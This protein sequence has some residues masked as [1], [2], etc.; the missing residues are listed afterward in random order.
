MLVVVAVVFILV[1]E[2]HLV[3]LVVEEEKTRKVL[4]IQD[5]VLV[6]LH[7]VVVQDIEEHMELSSSDINQIN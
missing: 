3:V 1:L 7:P 6:E 2:H 4:I 5:Q